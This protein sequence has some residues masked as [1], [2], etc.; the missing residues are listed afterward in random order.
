MKEGKKGARARR[1]AHSNRLNAEIGERNHYI[2]PGPQGQAYLM[3]K[4]F[5]LG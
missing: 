1:R 3:E 2:A 5:V 4:N